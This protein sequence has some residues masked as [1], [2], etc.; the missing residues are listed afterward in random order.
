MKDQSGTPE[1][2]SPQRRAGIVFAILAAASA[3]LLL[4]LPVLLLGI[5]FDALVAVM[6]GDVVA[7]QGSLDMTYVFIG[8]PALLSLVLLIEPY[9]LF[10]SAGRRL[11]RRRAIRW[12]GGLLVAWNA[13]VAMIWARE[14]MSRLTP[15]ERPETWYAAT[16]GIAAIVALIATVVAEKRAVRVAVALVGALAV[17]LLAL[18]AV[19][20]A[21]WGSPPRMS[22]GAQ[23]VHVVVTGSEVR[24]NPATVHGGEVYFVVEGPDD[25]AEHAGF[26]FVTAGFGPHCCDTPLP[27][28]DDAV[29]RLALGDYQGTSIEDGWGNYAKLTLVEGKY[30]FLIAGPGGDQPGAPPYSIVVL[31]VLP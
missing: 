7:W 25:P 13:G 20:V 3:G 29:D 28:T 8:I 30:A 22:A 31:E 10:R 12:V 19:L 26:T 11:G 27:L 2:G 9:A 6:R 16:F 24:L 5:T 18:G 23:T 14:A 17:G 1:A 4:F 21:V 15:A